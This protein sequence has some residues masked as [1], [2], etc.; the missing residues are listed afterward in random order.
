MEYITAKQKRFFEENGFLRLEGVFKP[1]EVGELSQEVD[2]IIHNFADWNAAWRG[3]WRKEYVDDPTEVEK[4]KLAAINDFHGHS[5]AWMRAILN[6]E[7]VGRVS[8]LMGADTLEFHHT[9]LHAKPP[10]QGA[11]FPMHQDM[12]FYSHENG[13]L[14]LDVLVHVDDADEETGCIKFL[15]GS[16]KMGALDH[17]IGPDTAPHLPTDKFRLEDAVPV[18]A[19]A[20]DVVVFY[21]WTIHGSA[22]NKSNRWRRIVRVGYRHPSNR[23]TGGHGLGQPGLIV[24]GVRPVAKSETK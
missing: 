19:K 23:Q 12:P 10:S 13:L 1:Q 3:E 2:Y 8:E 9:T 14:Y 20:G 21:L 16:H 5:A 22:M 15:K 18:P 6:P 17:I 11:P 7:L 4:V 24:K